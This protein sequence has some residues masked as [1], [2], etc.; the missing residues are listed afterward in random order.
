VHSTLNRRFAPPSPKR[1]GIVVALFML[2][3]STTV[4]ADSSA[5]ILRG[6][7]GDEEHAQKFTKW[8]DETRKA[9]VDKFGFSAD[10]V[11]VLADKM[12]A[13]AEI[14]KAF[15]T[16]KSQLKPLDTLFVFFIGHGSGEGDYKFNIFGPDFTAADY[17]MLLSSLSVGRI[18][19]VN[20]TNSSGAA[21]EAMAGKNRVIITATR[22]GQEGNDTVFYEYFLEALQKPEADEDKDQKI[23]VWEAFKYASA[24][25]DRFYKQEG[26]LVTEHPQISDNG[27]EKTTA[28]AKEV[29][30]L[31]R[32][33]VFQVDRPV[34]TNDPKLAALLNEKKDLEQKI[35]A[36]R[37][38][39][40]GIPEPEYEKQMEDL[41]VQLALKNQQ[42]K[43]QET[44]K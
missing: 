44:K 17:N 1:R 3:F 25:V 11:T 26:R 28:A 41:L 35:E 21:M 15:A 14:K 36:L 13:Q 37:I 34:V 23:S 31:A 24:G 10:R 38:G 27:A 5:L 43:A 9:L 42:I 33:L 8:S 4:L 40:S 32:T 30:L 12:T 29:P 7:A 6:V 18:V 22:S 19:I 20:G 16:L 39:K 2:L